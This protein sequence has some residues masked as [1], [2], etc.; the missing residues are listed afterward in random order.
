MQLLHCA[1]GRDLNEGGKVGLRAP[2][3]LAAR[4]TEARAAEFVE[5]LAD[6]V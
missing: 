5:P 6:L 4:E 2:V 3:M 1:P